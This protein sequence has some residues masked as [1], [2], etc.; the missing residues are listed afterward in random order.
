M[1]SSYCCVNIAILLWLRWVVSGLL[2]WPAFFEATLGPIC[3][4]IRAAVAAV[5]K[6][7]L[8]TR[9]PG[10]LHFPSRRA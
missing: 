7:L 3:D 5:T 4:V 8:C 10:W 2:G 6:P 1:N 9:G